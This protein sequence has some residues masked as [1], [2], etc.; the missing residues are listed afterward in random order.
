MKS[1]HLQAHIYF[2]IFVIAVMLIALPLLARPEP[3]HIAEVAPRLVHRAHLYHGIDFSTLDHETGE[4]FF[5]RD[6]KRCRLFTD[7]FWKRE[8]R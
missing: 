7:A 2:W 6:G 3:Q 5:V 8:G 1:N 4:R